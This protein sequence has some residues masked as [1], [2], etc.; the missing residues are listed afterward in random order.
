M[1]TLEAGG[2][3]L[4]NLFEGS[5]LPQQFALKSFQSLDEEA[6]N[7]ALIQKMMAEEE[8]EI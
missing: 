5:S 4:I 8:A 3:S 7:A 2:A 1:N 6:Q